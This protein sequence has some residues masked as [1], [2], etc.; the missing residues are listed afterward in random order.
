MQNTP[1]R[2]AGSSVGTAPPAMHIASS[3]KV[4][5]EDVLQGKLARVLAEF[6]VSNCHITRRGGVAR[7]PSD[8][9]DCSCGEISHFVI[10]E[11]Q[12]LFSM[13]GIDHTFIHMF[14]AESTQYCVN[15]GQV[16]I[17]DDARYQRGDFK[18]LQQDTHWC[19]R[20][21]KPR[22]APPPWVS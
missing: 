6:V 22:V 20:H 9:T 4:T 17:P 11:L 8:A 14:L 16:A 3:A 15:G 2:N 18:T 13:H 5:A 19:S 7:T 10:D 1:R 21:N 12:S